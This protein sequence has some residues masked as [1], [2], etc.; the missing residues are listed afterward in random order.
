[1]I[2]KNINNEVYFFKDVFPKQL[3]DDCLIY[4]DTS[5]KNNRYDI[6]MDY[7]SPDH[8]MVH[9]RQDVKINNSEIVDIYQTE[10][11]KV[12]QKYH[13]IPENY[14]LFKI[15]HPY[16]EAALSSIYKNMPIGYTSNYFR[17]EAGAFMNKHQDGSDNRICTTVLYLNTMLDEYSGGEILF[18]DEEDNVIYTHR[19]SS[20]DL[21]LFDSSTSNGMAHSVNRIK[22]WERYVHR[23]YW[24]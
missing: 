16:Y 2:Y 3:I 23:T 11:F 21:I 12:V 8:T 20:G 17:Y 15:L 6:R 18:Y 22:N 24:K 13:E 19:P 4:I 9:I 1:M 14:S 10:K 7:Q 5:L